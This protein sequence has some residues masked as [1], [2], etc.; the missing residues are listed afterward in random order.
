MLDIWAELDI[1]PMVLQH[2]QDLEVGDQMVNVDEIADSVAR[3][4][5]MCVDLGFPKCQN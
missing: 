1:V 4:C 2:G 5:L 3:K